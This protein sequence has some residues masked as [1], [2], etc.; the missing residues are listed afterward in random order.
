MAIDTEA[1]QAAPLVVVEAARSKAAITVLVAG[2]IDISTSSRLR[3]ELFELLGEA[4]GAAV[5]DMT[6]VRFCDSSGL[7]VLVQLNRHCQEA[8]ID[9]SFAPSKVL[10]RALELT[11]LL[12]TLKVTGA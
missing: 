9:L 11:G 2:D 3:T 10:R 7:S 4:P 12:P 8:G 1:G 5:I 6:G